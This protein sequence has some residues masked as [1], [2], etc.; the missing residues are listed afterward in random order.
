M[1]AASLAVGVIALG[2][3]AGA[4]AEPATVPAKDSFSGSISSGTGRYKDDRGTASSYLV[5][6]SSSNATRRLTLEIRGRPC[7]RSKHCL[8]LSGNLKG[9]LTAIPPQ[10]ADVGQSFTVNVRGRLKPLGPVSVKGTVHGTGFLIQ[11]EETLSL[12]ITA[13]GGQINL[14]AISPP[15]SGFTSP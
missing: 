7:G 2:A 1:R 5:L 15:V 8:K 6:S 13:P 10:V 12:T 14:S 9:T 4:T 3:S 11:G